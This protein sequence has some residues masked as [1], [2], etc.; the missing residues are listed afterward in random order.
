MASG[1]GSR[2][3]A[4]LT[5]VPSRMLD[6]SRASPARVIH[7]SVDPGPGSPLIALEVVGPEESVEAQPLRLLRD[8]EEIVVRRALLRLGHDA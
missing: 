4:E 3:V 2:N 7:A 8:D 6:V 1:P 5:I